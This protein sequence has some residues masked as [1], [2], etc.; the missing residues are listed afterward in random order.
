VYSRSIITIHRFSL[1]SSW[2]KSLMPLPSDPAF[3]SA[4]G[5]PHFCGVLSESRWLHSHRCTCCASGC[6]NAA[7]DHF[8]RW[9]TGPF[10]EETFD[11]KPSIVPA[12]L[13]THSFRLPLHP[14]SSKELGRHHRMMLPHSLHRA[15]GKNAANRFAFDGRPFIRAT[16]ELHR[17]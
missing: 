10:A 6:R 4:R 13:V 11:P 17:V 3:A 5:L 14:A 12:H 8:R 2:H 16:S 1:A 9:I 15:A 7:P